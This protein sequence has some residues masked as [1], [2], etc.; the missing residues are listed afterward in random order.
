[1]EINTFITEAIHSTINIIIVVIV[2]FNISLFIFFLSLSLITFLNKCIP[3]DASTSMA[4]INIIF[5]N[6][7]EHIEN[8][9]PLSA[10]NVPI[11]ADIV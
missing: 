10:P 4:G 7:I 8:M 5:C 1:M 11:V 3:L 9:L 2:C 6:N